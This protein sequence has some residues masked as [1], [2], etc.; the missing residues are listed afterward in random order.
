MECT[1]L[2]EMDPSVDLQSDPGNVRRLVGA[3]IRDGCSN[4][5]D[6][7][8]AAERNLCKNLFE[9]CRGMGGERLLNAVR[10]NDTRCDGV[11]GDPGWP[12]L[13]R[14]LT[15][16]AEQGRLGRGISDSTDDRAARA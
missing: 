4:V 15:G 10:L 16:E 1:P 6:A 5:L 8:G 3:K 9:A 2:T 13:L 11:Y 14:E 12:E 7:A